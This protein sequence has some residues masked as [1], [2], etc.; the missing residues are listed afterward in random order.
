MIVALQCVF[1]LMAFYSGSWVSDTVVER[2]QPS[3]REALEW[4]YLW[5]RVVLLGSLVTGVVVVVGT[6]ATRHERPFAFL[7]ILI[8]FS[9]SALS[10]IAGATGGVLVHEHGINL[11]FTEPQREMSSNP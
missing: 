10:L 7:A 11:L 4:H 3:A 1:S 5:G 9:L 8:S 2:L 6:I